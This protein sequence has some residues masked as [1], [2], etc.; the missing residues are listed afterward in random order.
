MTFKNSKKKIKEIAR[1]VN[2]RYVL[3]GSVRKA[4]NNLR[5]TAQLIDATNDAHLWAE[6]Y[7][8]TLEDIFDIQEKVSRSIVDALMVKLK[9]T[10][11]DQITERPIPNLIA[12][13]HYL[14]ARHGIYSFTKEGLNTAL[15]HLKKGLEIIGENTLLL[16]GIGLV[17]YQQINIGANSDKTLIKEI[18]ECAQQ[19]LS[20]DPDGPHG[21]LLLGLAEGLKGDIR[22]AVIQLHRAYVLDP[23]D[24]DTMFWLG[25]CSFS[26][27]QTDL[28]RKL[29]DTLVIVDPL[30]PLS[31]ALIGAAAFFE[32]R[33]NDI[34][35]PIKKAVEIGSDVPVVM[36][37]A[38]R[39]LAA[40]GDKSTAFIVAEQFFDKHSDTMFAKMS[41]SLVLALQG[42]K[43]A[44]LAE[45][46][47]DLR[48]WVWND[49]EWTQALSE[50]Y[51]LA[52]DIEEAINL[53]EHAV[54]GG[55]INYPFLNEYD[56]FLKNIRGEARFK[57]LMER[58]KQEWENFEL[59]Q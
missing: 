50:C 46:T 29:F 30:N 13:D 52:G 1:E 59:E 40:S 20:L 10:E 31:H 38:I 47:D 43:K 39:Q 6:K 23:N 19:I 28:F 48:N 25:V 42:K 57:K 35:K 4:G 41:K 12:Y 32:G 58:V 37:G 16:K 27:G 24:P 22:R 17:R 53:L 45:I 51:A 5:I 33:F 49:C 3:E 14:R 9:S 55:F 18:E 21:Y 34:S 44:A 26:T 56:P 2:V 11:Y 15:E 7:K 54:D 36:W 8:G